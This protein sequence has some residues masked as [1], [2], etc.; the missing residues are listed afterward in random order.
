MKNK[1]IILKELLNLTKKAIKNNEVPNSA[2]L[3]DLN[4]KILFKAHNLNKSNNSICEHAE[5]V[6]INKAIKNNFEFNLKDLILISTHEPCMMCLG[7]IIHAKIKNIIYLYDQPKFG[8]L[9]S[10]FNFDHTKINAKK[11][12]LSLKESLQFKDKFNFFFLKLRNKN[13]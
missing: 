1:N 3:V 5:I 12:N 9:N 11:L 2:V 7:A 13:K 4:F 6:V 10:N 8:F